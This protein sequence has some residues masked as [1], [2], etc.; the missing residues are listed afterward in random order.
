LQPIVIPETDGAT[1]PFFSADGSHL[2]F[3]DRGHALEIMSLNGGPPTIVTDADIGTG[4]D[5]WGKDGF[6]YVDGQYYGRMLRVRAERGARPEWFTTLDTTAGEIDHNW[7]DVLPNGKGVLFAITSGVKRL[8]SGSLSYAIGVAEPVSVYVDTHGTGK[9]DEDKLAEAV[10]K[11]FDLTPKGIIAALDLRRPIFK[12]TAKFGHF[13]RTNDEFTW[14]KT[15]KADALMGALS[16]A[17][18][19]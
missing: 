10:R 12:Q 18:T 5:A 4:G 1:T 8:H 19:V 11:N 16:N 6:I 9:V 3:V 7:P 2:G 17:T 15:D 14:E 13:G